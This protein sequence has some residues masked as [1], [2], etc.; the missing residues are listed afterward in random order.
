MKTRFKLKVSLVRIFRQ[1]EELM[2]S[3]GVKGLRLEG[4]IMRGHWKLI[5]LIIGM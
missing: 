3:P 2:S 5:W 1:E 4:A